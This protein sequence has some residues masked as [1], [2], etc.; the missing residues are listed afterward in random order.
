MIQEP[1]FSFPALRLN[2]GGRQQFI[3]NWS[4]KTILLMLGIFADDSKHGAGLRLNHPRVRK[5]TN[6][7]LEKKEIPP[8]EP[9]IVV[10]GNSSEF[11]PMEAMPESGFGMLSLPFTDILD[12]CDGIHRIAALKTLKFSGIQI[13]TSEWPIEFIECTD[14]ADAAQLV[15]RLRGD[16]SS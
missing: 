7:W 8:F 9:L 13:S 3:A 2:K 15:S 1:A 12:V 14:L 10:I 11:S 5:L 16:E 4:L 6:Q